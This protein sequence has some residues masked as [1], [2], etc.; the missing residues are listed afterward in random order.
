MRLGNGGNGGTAE[1]TK[2][3]EHGRATGGDG[4]SGGN[5][6]M[7]AG[8]KFD[9]IGSFDIYPG[10]AGDGG[11]AIADGR[12]GENDLVHHAANEHGHAHGHGH[13]SI[14]ETGR[15]SPTGLEQF[16]A[17]QAGEE[18]AGDTGDHQSLAP[19]AEDEVGGVLGDVVQVRLAAL[20][21]ALAG[22]AAGTDGDERLAAV[23]TDAQGVDF[24]GH[25]KICFA[26]R[27][28]G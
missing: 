25:R 18:A 17:D 20:A 27:P 5:F 28:C 21:P 22:Q 12:T 14:E 2:D 13:T 7:V 24:I 6:K 16:V 19:V 8:D 15:G 10:K 11:K 9:I 3:C 4:G 23:P 1:T 26:N